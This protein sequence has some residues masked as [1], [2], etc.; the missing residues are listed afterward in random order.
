VSPTA[1]QVAA[2]L[3]S[4]TILALKY[5]KKGMVRPGAFDPYELAKPY[6]GTIINDDLEIKFPAKWSEMIV[7]AIESTNSSYKVHTRKT[8]CSA[9]FD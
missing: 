4:H 1:L 6:L 5:P 2:G 8:F 7:D 9:F 3:Y